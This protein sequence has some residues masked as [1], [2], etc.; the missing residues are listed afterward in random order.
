MSSKE[1]ARMSKSIRI[2]AAA[3]LACAFNSVAQAAVVT[4][5]AGR[6]SFRG[7]WY[8]TC[9]P[10]DRSDPIGLVA[11]PASVSL[12]GEGIDLLG[13]TGQAVGSGM[14]VGSVTRDDVSGALLGGTV[15]GGFT[16]S[17]GPQDFMAT[18]GSVTISNVVFDIATKRVTADIAGHRQAYQGVT[19]EDFT[20]TGVSLWSFSQLVGPASFNPA[21]PYGVDGALRAQYTLSGLVLTTEGLGAFTRGLGLLP[22]GQGALQQSSM[23]ALSMELH[24]GHSVAAVPEPSAWALMGVGLV[25][26]AGVRRFK[27]KGAPGA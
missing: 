11:S 2:L 15:T 1:D 13:V 14:V 4:D 19:A 6:E 27:A 5:V 3:A 17:V 25:G 7:C 8:L 9:V 10:A 21:T 18:G 23:G 24:Y 12:Q 26:L 22:F 20:L 16:L